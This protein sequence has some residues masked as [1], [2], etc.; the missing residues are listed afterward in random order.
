[1]TKWKVATQK[2]YTFNSSEELT[3]FLETLNQTERLLQ[4]IKIKDEETQ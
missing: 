2:I 3:A 4:T 1:M